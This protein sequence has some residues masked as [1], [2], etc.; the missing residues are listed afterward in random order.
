MG[1]SAPGAARQAVSALEAGDAR[2]DAGAEISQ[3][4]VDPAAFDHVFDGEAGLFVEGHIAH[5]AG[6]GP[7]EVVET[8]I[9][10][11]GGRLAGWTA[12]EGV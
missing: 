3:L 10:A 12:I 7:T 4:A 5:A 8:G 2:L 1:Q 9:A 11:I 6:F